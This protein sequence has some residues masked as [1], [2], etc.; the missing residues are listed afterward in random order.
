VPKTKVFAR[1]LSSKVFLWCVMFAALFAG[2]Q[3]V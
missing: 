1:R 3:F 2:I